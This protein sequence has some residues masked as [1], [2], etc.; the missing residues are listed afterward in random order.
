MNAVDD[1]NNDQIDCVSDGRCIQMATHASLKDQI[2]M[3][4]KEEDKLENGALNCTYVVN[5]S[6]PPPNVFKPTSSAAAKYN[7]NDTEQPH[8]A[9]NDSDMYMYVIPKLS[10]PPHLFKP[11]NSTSMCTRS[12]G[13]K[14]P[15]IE[16]SNDTC[17]IP[18]SL[19]FD[20]PPLPNPSKP[21]SM[22]TRSKKGIK[23]PDIVIEH[24]NN[25]YVVPTCVSP[26]RPSASMTMRTRSMDTNSPDTEQSNAASTDDNELFHTP[27]ES[28]KHARSSSAE[29]C[30]DIPAKIPASDE[31][32]VLITDMQSNFHP[33][34][35][36]LSS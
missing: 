13:T 23:S 1:D 7:V 28:Q 16:Q 33:E 10:P 2:L 8:V 29:L 4:E 19:P 11:S 27:C 21:T 17:P 35:V 15:D 5:K 12:N 18:K 26:P 6:P 32:D 34:K 30:T 36:C 24:S 14:S 3:E 25:T 9:S 22:C 20:P 31:D